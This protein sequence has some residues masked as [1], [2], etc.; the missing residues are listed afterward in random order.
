MMRWE[1]IAALQ[2]LS[3]TA[4]ATFLRHWLGFRLANF[5]GSREMVARRKTIISARGLKRSI[6]FYNGRNTQWQISQGVSLQKS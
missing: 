1:I 4:N 3:G 2:P 6:K 5:Q